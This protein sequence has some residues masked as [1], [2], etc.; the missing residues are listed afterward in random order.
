[1][2]VLW[3]FSL[4]CSFALFYGQWYAP[5][6]YVVNPLWPLIG[7]YTFQLRPRTHTELWSCP[8]CWAFPGRVEVSGDIWMLSEVGWWED[9]S[10]WRWED[11]SQFSQRSK[12]SMYS[13]AAESAT[14]EELRSKWILDPPK[15]THGNEGL[16][17]FEEEEL[18]LGGGVVTFSASMTLTEPATDPSHEFR[19]SSFWMLFLGPFHHEGP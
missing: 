8:V 13:K 9:I 12:S 16:A 6:F 10:Q 11:I 2:M 14:F 18:R 19:L 15:T 17:L 4:E 3:S 7:P 5:Y 1:M